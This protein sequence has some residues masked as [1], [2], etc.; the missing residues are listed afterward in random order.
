METELYYD[1]QFFRDSWIYIL[2]G[3][4]Y[5]LRHYATNRKIA[6]SIPDQV[7]FKFT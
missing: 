4:H 6:G 2:K 1:T 7:I 5:R 3:F